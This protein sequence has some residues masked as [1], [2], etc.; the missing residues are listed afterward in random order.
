MIF[1]SIYLIN[2]LNK[3]FIKHLY[4]YIKKCLAHFQVIFKL[5]FQ[6]NHVMDLLRDIRKYK[7]KGF[8]MRSLTFN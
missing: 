6:I 2:Y 5:I 7:N 8:A 3:T 1:F 4:L